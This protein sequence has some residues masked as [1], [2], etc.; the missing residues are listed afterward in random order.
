MLIICPA[1]LR[2]NWQR[3]CEKWLTR[4]FSIQIIDGGAPV[5]LTGDIIII[6]YDVVPKH[7]ASIDTV[8]WGMLIADEAHYLKG[9]K[10]KRTISIFGKR[11]NAKKGEEPIPAIAARRRLLLTGTPIVNKPI[12]LWTLIS[13]LNPTVFN[14]FFSFAKRYCN[15]NQN[16]YGW[17]FSGAKNLDELQDTLRSSVMVRRMKADVLKELPP[18]RRQIISLEDE[19]SAVKNE[20]KKSLEIEGQLNQLQAKLEIAEATDVDTQDILD[21]IRDAQ[22]MAF[23]EMALARHDTAVAK[24]PACLA[25]IIECL[26]SSERLVVFAHH[27]DVIDGLLAG[28]AEANISAVSLTGETP[29]EARQASVDAFQAGKAQIFLGNIQAA[30]VGITLTAA[31]H[32][33]FCELPWTPA[34]LSQA[35]DRCHRIGQEESVLVQH[36]VLE[37]SIDQ[38][39]AQALVDKQEIIDKALDI[40]VRQKLQ[41]APV[42]PTRERRQ[43]LKKDLIAAIA[44]VITPEQIEAAHQAMKQLAGMD[45]DHARA[46]NNVGFSKIDVEIGHDLA[47]RPSLSVKQGAFAAVLARKYRRQIDITALENLFIEN[48]H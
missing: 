11:G 34:E 45:E 2:L 33:I 10:T 23:T 41:A 16:R 36:I 46:I 4:K 42:I 7:R 21:Q 20:G 39:M 38:R 13:Y 25:H 47:N 19:G 26:E 31:S 5:P 37:N 28:L 8:S 48:N 32:V 40:M 22:K 12:E 14:N 17:D 44:L 6:N 24:I 18:K 3:E 43:S 35:E 29:M 30:G 9:A 15:A 27:H 1:S